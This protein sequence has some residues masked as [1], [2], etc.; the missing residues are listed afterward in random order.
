MS[1][2][3]V[4]LS[5]SVPDPKR[6]PQYFSTG[7]TVAIRDAVIALAQV[8]LPRT[9]LVFGGHPA[10]TP[11]VK[12]V[13]DQENLFGNVR[14]FQSKFFQKL[15]IADV[16]RFAYKEVDAVGGPDAT[17]AR[18]ASLLAM[19]SAMLASEHFSAA[20]FIGGMEGVEAEFELVR[21]LHYRVPC[22][23]VATTG[24]AAAK[25]WKRMQADGTGAE[26]S[27]FRD[28]PTKTAYTALFTEILET[29]L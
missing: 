11:M 16:K 15:Y 22:Y 26:G 25:L 2:A 5:A 29:R 24:A 9:K 7:N 28:L 20:F 3:P 8:V 6:D 10:I 19:R 1:V 4:F 21:K 12:W 18:D 13:A 23:P 17:A 27:H 14:L